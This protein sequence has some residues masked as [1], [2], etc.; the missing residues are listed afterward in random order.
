VSLAAIFDDARS[1]ARFRDVPVDPAVLRVIH[2][3]MKWGPTSMNC[4]PLRI[5]W[6]VSAQAR[7]ALSECVYE[8]NRA[9]VLA[10][11]VC[12]VLGMDLAFV[13]TLEKLFPHKKDAVAY[14][15][16]KPQLVESTALRNSSLQAAYLLV[17]ARME[18]LDCGPM[19]GFHQAQVDR[20]CWDGTTVKTNFL[21]NM[22]YGDRSEM[23]ERNL[24]WSFED[25]C[26]VR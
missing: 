7:Q 8:G 17:A 2:E 6:M 23:R 20:L 18:G 3:H 14:Y 13:P 10:A 22:G 25:V 11:P 5:R 1:Y 26:E 16:G 9:K 12:A 21:C 19:S 15:D 24:R 4:Q